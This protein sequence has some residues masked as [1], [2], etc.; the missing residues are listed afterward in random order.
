MLSGHRGMSVDAQ[1]S[2]PTMRAAGAR[3]TD[4][5]LAE[6]HN[7]QNAGMQPG[8]VQLPQPMQRRKKQAGDGRNGPFSRDE[9]ASDAHPRGGIGSKLRRDAGI[10]LS[11]LARTLLSAAL[12]TTSTH[13]VSAMRNTGSRLR[14]DA[15]IHLSPLALESR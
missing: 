14:R 9:R 7:L 10:H 13:P 12:P 2:R 1:E 15:G 11:M 4:E 5:P 6:L 8:V 3:E